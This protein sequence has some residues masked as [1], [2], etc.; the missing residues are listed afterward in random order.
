M[1]QWFS[2]IPRWFWLPAFFLGWLAGSF[3][4]S[5]ATVEWQAADESAVRNL[6]EQVDEL[7]LEVAKGKPGPLGPEGPTGPDGPRGPKGPKGD[8][9]SLG[10]PGLQGPP[11]PSGP[12]GPA[13]TSVDVSLLEFHMGEVFDCLEEF[14]TWANEMEQEVFNTF[15]YGTTFFS[16]FGP[17]CVT[18]GVPDY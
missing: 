13:G 17:I 3:G 11:G 8:Q 5:F 15:L 9:G 14:R 1:R 7:A 10:P 4:V 18:V 6:E 12:A 2:A 16:P